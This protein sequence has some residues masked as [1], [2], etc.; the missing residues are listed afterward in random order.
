MIFV[1]GVVICGGPFKVLGL[2]EVQNTGLVEMWIAK[3]TEPF[4]LPLNKVYISVTHPLP[5]F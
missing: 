2:E 1:P 4:L 3:T 5:C